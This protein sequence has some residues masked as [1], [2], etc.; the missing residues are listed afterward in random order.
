MMLHQVS[1]DAEI[2]DLEGDISVQTMSGDVEARNLKGSLAAKAVS[3]DIEVKSSD[4]RAITVE[5]V[6]GDTLIESALYAEGDYH[7]R[8]ISGNLILRVPEDQR[9][10]I[11]CRTLSGDVKTKLPH[12]TKRQGWG[13][14]EVAVNGGGVEFDVTSTSGDVKVEAADEVLEATDESEE[15]N[16]VHEHAAHHAPHAHE[17]RPLQA[18]PVQG[19]PFHVDAEPTAEPSRAE[20]RMRILKAIELG[21]LSVEQGLAKLRE[22]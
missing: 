21:D 13:K 14:V 18:K 4:L 1:G 11:L 3:G 5:A 15:L 19:E 10:T 2:R 7:A 6:S 8:S 20:Q 9:C 17:T 12:V 16:E 22:I